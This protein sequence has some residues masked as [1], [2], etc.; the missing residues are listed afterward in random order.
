MHIDSYSFGRMVI[1]G[2]EYTKDVIV[3]PDHV[4]DGWWR[5]Q[6]HYLKKEDLSDVFQ[7]DPD[8]LVLGTGMSGILHVPEKTIDEIQ[9][10]NI[11]FIPGI[12]ENAVHTF[13]KKLSNDTNAV[14]AFHL[15]C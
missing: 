9:H 2:K 10:K 1:D 13:N 5:E 3:F 7:Y 8:V 11:K 4:I 12:T 15:T 6:G 14:G